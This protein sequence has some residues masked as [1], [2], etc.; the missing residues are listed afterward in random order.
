MGE[1]TEEVD[2]HEAAEECEVCGGGEEV[3]SAESCAEY[4]NVQLMEAGDG[5]SDHRLT[6]GLG[7]DV[8]SEGEGGGGEGLALEGNGGKSGRVD[9]DEDEV[10][11]ATGVGQG[12]ML[13]NTR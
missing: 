9:V 2:V 6:G 10:T 5:L 8:D 1:G 12:D 13:A 3:M 7:G 11:S 4:Q